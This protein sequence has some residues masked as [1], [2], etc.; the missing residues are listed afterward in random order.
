MDMFRKK[1]MEDIMGLVNSSQL[2]KT[3]KA[4]DIACLGMGAVIGTGI[5]VVTGLGAHLAGPAIIIS[6][7]NFSILL[8]STTPENFPITLNSSANIKATPNK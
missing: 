7:M 1:S 3:L 6:F 5:F 8:S 2:K 4:K